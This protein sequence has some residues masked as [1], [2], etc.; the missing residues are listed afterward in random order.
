MNTEIDNISKLFISQM[1]DI[2]NKAIYQFIDNIVSKYDNISKSELISLW[3]NDENIPSEKPTQI[4]FNLNPVSNPV[5][6]ISKSS[7][8]QYM[9]RKGD[10]KGSLCPEK[11]TR[12]GSYCSRHKKYEGQT[13]LTTQPTSEKPVPQIETPIKKLELELNPI[14]KKYWNDE[15]GFVVNSV[16]EP[17]IY[18]KVVDN[19]I[20]LLNTDDCE[21]CKKYNWDYTEPVHTVMFKEFQKGLS[22]YIEKHD[23]IQ[24]DYDTKKLLDNILT[25]TRSNNITNWKKLF[26]PK[27]GNM[28]CNTLLE[29]NIIIRQEPDDTKLEQAMLEMEI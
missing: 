27:Y 6:A 20:V 8:C 1:T 5:S 7:T 3:K 22:Y 26:T 12:G 17:N 15:T 19:S 21:L 2:T 11:P 16:S 24:V 13:I 25:L 23:F 28:L 29:N 14:V 18:G 4:K 9:I 10:K